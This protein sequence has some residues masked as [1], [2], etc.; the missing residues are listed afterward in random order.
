[1]ETNRKPIAR[2]TDKYEHTA[3]GQVLGEFFCAESQH[4]RPIKL[5]VL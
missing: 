4:G 1:M 3:P 2:K 5:Y